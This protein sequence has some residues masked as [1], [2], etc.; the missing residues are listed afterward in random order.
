ML[1]ADTDFLSSFLKIDRL[2]LVKDFFREDI[3]VPVAVQR[4]IAKTDLI[5][6]LNEKK[7]VH[8]VNVKRKDM[9]GSEF[10]GEGEI[11]CLSL[12]TENDL[13]LMNDRVAGRIGE[14]NKIKVVN[15]PGF[16]L[17]LRES[18]FL[19]K[20]EL[21]KTVKGLKE[22]DFYLLSKKDEEEI[23]GEKG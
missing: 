8:V 9:A 13:V 12:A 18:G 15:I 23:T 20:S 19:D 10:L 21:K 5:I 3:Y 7:F 17:V 11:E 6:K 22:R 16:L 4:E 1:I 2:E 14:S